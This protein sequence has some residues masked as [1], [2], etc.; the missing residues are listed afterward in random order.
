MYWTDWS[1]QS[2]IEKAGMDGSNRRVIVDTGQ[3]GWPNGLTVDSK[4]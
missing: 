3:G 4:G 2:R 1:P